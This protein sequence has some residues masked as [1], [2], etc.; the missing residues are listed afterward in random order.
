M[1]VLSDELLF[2]VEKNG[3]ILINKNNFSRLEL[4]ESE[5]IF[6]SLVKEM[7]KEKAF[8]EYIKYFNADSLT[9]ILREKIYK[10]G[11][12]EEKEVSSF[13]IINKI[14]SKIKELKKLNQMSF[15][16]ELVIYPSMYCNLHCGFC[17]LANRE[18]ENVHLADDWKKILSQAKENG[19][20]SFSILGGEPT[21]YKDIN[22]LL[23]IIDSLKVVT[24]ITTNGQEI[25]K[26][27]IDI[28]CQSD[29]ITPVI[30]LESIDDFKNFE[31]MGT[32]AKRGIELIKL[33]H[34]RKKKVRLNTVYSNQ[35]EEDIM[36]L[37][38][39]AIKN[40]IDRF[41][42][43]DYSEVTGFTKIT[44]IY[45]ISDLRKLEEKVRRYLLD[46]KIDNFNFSVEGCF[47]F[48]AFP[49]LIEEGKNLSEFENM[50]FGCRAKHT[51]MEILSNGDV[52]PCI[53]F[54]GEKHN[55]NAFHQTLAEIW[56]ND[57]NYT[58]VREFKTENKDCLKCSMLRI[59]E[60]GC[61]PKLQRT[62]NPNFTKDKTCQL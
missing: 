10:K 31:L 18:D 33:F 8:N 47:Y 43:A 6:L 45:N 49:E 27:T 55:S 36:E 57:S 56:K 24:T 11:E 42:I 48:T 41:S 40:E 4:S 7:G 12:I 37:L 15:P 60:G 9:K 3:G 25:K 13:S 39:F 19:I 54:L 32:R 2:R 61:Y 52:L 30:S 21:K 62:L 51:K 44:K 20:L 38:K 26:S 50:Y 59:C 35:S 34:E 29:Y 5:S 53:A 1:Y 58:E 17:F 46:N 28:I 22:N 16:L 23:K 14:Q